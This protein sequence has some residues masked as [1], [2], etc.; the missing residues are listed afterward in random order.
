MPVNARTGAGGDSRRAPPPRRAN[1][2]PVMVSSRGYYQLLGI[3]NSAD[4]AEIKKA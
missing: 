1:S 3:D 2:T 4:S